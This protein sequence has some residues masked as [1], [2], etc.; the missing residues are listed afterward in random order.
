MNLKSFEKHIDGK[1]K[2]GVCRCGH[3]WSEHNR[4]GIFSILS[5][6]AVSACDDCK[7]PY[8]VR[9]ARLTYDEAMILKSQ[10]TTL[11]EK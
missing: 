7:C 9:Y 6:T 10:H 4:F 11:G 8:Y 1:H 3:F 2:Y 5:L